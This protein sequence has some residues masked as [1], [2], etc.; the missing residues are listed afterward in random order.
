MIPSQMRK[1]ILEGCILTIIGQEEIYGYEISEKLKTMGFGDISEG[2]IYPI[3][4]RLTRNESIQ[5]T[6]KDSPSGPQRKYY[7]LTDKGQ[8]EVTEFKRDW[9]ELVSAVN[10]LIKE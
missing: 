3:L 2:T 4:L 6:L 8:I 9:Q 7:S 5:A 10:Q 1:G